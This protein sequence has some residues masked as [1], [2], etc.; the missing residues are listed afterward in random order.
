MANLGTIH[1]CTHILKSKEESKDQG[2]MQLST[3]PHLWHHKGKWQKDK[4]Q[5]SEEGSSSTAGG[6]KVAKEQTI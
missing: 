3:T 4:T 2:S 6:H 5:K 1:A